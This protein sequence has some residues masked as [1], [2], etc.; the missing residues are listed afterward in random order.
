MAEATPSNVNLNWRP[1]PLIPDRRLRWLLGLGIAL[2]LAVAFGTMNVDWARVAEGGPRASRF[3]SG[4]FPPDFLSRWD[5]IL[6]GLME[7]L[8]MTVVSTALG[9]LIS[10]PVAIGGARNLAP[11]PVYIFCRSI[12]F[13]IGL[14][15]SP[16]LNTIKRGSPLTS[17]GGVLTRL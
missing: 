6:D 9:V 1:P 15:L 16:Q 12:M 17:T 5:A 14:V 7:S 8:W 3:F 10:I 4:F 11:M 13:S 2:Y